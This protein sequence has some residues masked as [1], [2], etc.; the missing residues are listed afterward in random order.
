ARFEADLRNRRYHGIESYKPAPV[1]VA[2]TGAC[3]RPRT[4][5]L[6]VHQNALSQHESEAKRCG[7]GR[8]VSKFSGKI[9]GRRG[10]AGRE[11][12][13]CDSPGNGEHYSRGL[14][15]QGR[16]SRRV[17][18]LS[19]QTPQGSADRGREGRFR[20]GQ[21]RLSSVNVISVGVKG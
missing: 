15:R 4:T 8:S 6:A 2:E 12:A 14:R 20:S 19:L 11:T 3:S 7:G 13:F 9:G 10:G 21:R 5:R 16:E 18:R 1:C 17:P